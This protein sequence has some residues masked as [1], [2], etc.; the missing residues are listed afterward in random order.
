MI[1]MAKPVLGKEEEKAVIAVLRSGLL[2]QGKK[3]EE[4][5]TN[6][7]KYIGAKYA[8]AVTNGTAALH[9]SLLAMGIKEGDEV[10]TTPFSFIASANAIKYVGAKP[11]F[12]DIDE[13]TLTIDPTEIEK[14]ITK[15]TCA[16]IP[17]HLF[18]LPA[19]MPEIRKIA[20]K[21][22]LKILEDAC[23][24]HGAFIGNKKVGIWGDAAC[25]SFYPTKNITSGEGGMITTNDKII[26][27]NLRLLRSHGMKKRYHHEILGYN[28]RLTDIAAAIG[29]VQ[30][31]KLDS[32]NKKR[33][34]N[35][36]VYLKEL[37]NVKG[38]ILPEIPQG[39]NHVFNQF[40]IRITNEYPLGRDGLREKLESKGIASEIYYPIPIHKQEYY[41]NMGYK[42]ELPFSEN[43]SNTV[44]SIPIHPQLLEEDIIK[45][46]KV[47]KI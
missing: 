35:A 16:I 40:T 43:A 1:S 46:I 47:L 38:L 9:L 44:L 36:E 7:A 39:Y 33:Q 6:F 5:E 4:F 28:L 32:F 41:K 12:A 29:V 25:F 15:K 31:K 22:N 21:H 3:V 13:S 30:L 26:A 17:V 42:D 8:V 10:I 34:K 45:V 24:S 11:V 27:E 37:K 19:N 18:G 23:Q 2:A 14:K 20:K